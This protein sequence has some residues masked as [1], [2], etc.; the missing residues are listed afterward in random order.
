MKFRANEEKERG[1]EEAVKYLTNRALSP[2]AQ[3][4]CKATLSDIIKAHGPVITHYPCWHPLL[5]IPQTAEKN[6]DRNTFF[7]G[8]QSAGYPEHQEIDHLIF[9]QRGFI[10]C[11][12]TSGA[13]LRQFV[14]KFPELEIQK[15]D[16]PLYGPRTS[17]W[18]VT[19][20]IPLEEDGT[21]ETQSVLKWIL[22]S[23]PLGWAM[24][25]S[26]WESI[27]SNLLGSPH[28][29]KSSLLVN[30]KTGQAIK[31]IWETLNKYSCQTKG[32]RPKN[33]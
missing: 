4:A 29:A 2:Q 23:N 24:D 9:L 27:K 10:T 16:A 21:L 26:S 1:T 13:K 14:K 20:D 11:P 25:D 17:R 6:R 28:G 18:L 33:P 15:I 22:A 5:R 8:L 7:D 31:E 19:V 12:Y 3:E 30:Q 32:Q